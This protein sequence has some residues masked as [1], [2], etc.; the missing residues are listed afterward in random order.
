MLKAISGL[1]R[2]AAIDLQCRCYTRP[3]PKTGPPSGRVFKDDEWKWQLD[4]RYGIVHMRTARWGNRHVY[5]KGKR[6]IFRRSLASNQAG[7]RA[8]GG[9]CGDYGDRSEV[10][11]VVEQLGDRWQSRVLVDRSNGAVDFVK[12]TA[13]VIG[14]KL[15]RAEPAPAG[16]LPGETG[17]GPKARLKVGS[18]R[19]IL[20]GKSTVEKRRLSI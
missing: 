4:R 20:N 9:R 17:S 1:L 8:G 10:M 2:E 18:M 15:R 5:R 16:K 6:S 3:L 14:Y 11:E 12:Q 19:D 7:A 13:I